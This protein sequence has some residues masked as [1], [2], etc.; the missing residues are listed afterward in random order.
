MA[1]WCITASVSPHFV[2]LFLFACVLRSAIP[3][4]THSSSTPP[5][6]LLL[7]FNSGSNQLR[8]HIVN[9]AQTQNTWRITVGLVPPSFS[10]TQ[11]SFTCVGSSQGGWAYV[12]GTGKKYSRKSGGEQA[13][14]VSYTTG[15]YVDIFFN[16]DSGQI[17]FAK[18][19]HHHGVAYDNLAGPV[20]L[21]VS[22]TGC[23]SKVRIAHIKGNVGSSVFGNEPAAAYSAASAAADYKRAVPQQS[24]PSGIPATDSDVIRLRTLETDFRGKLPNFILHLSDNEWLESLT[25]IAIMGFDRVQAA[26]ALIVTMEEHKLKVEAA[27]EYLLK[28]DVSKRAKYEKERIA[29]QAVPIDAASI[30]AASV[31][32]SAPHIKRLE[33]QVTDLLSQL[34]LERGKVAQHTVVLNRE[35]YKEALASCLVDGAITAA[36]IQRLEILRRK[37]GIE[38]GEHTRI[39]RELGV[40]VDDWDSMLDKGRDYDEEKLSESHTA[41]DL[42]RLTANTECVVCMERVVDHVVLDC[43]HVCYCGECAEMYKDSVKKCPKCR[44]AVRDIKKLFF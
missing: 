38:E 29:A 13:Y 24:L 41:S 12:G 27:I 11:R 7:S 23:G 31:S 22:M 42:I 19:G 6:L 39:L 5:P 33:A 4:L 3:P 2:S 14:G 36:E 28:D 16:F 34:Q 37:R 18:N 44:A 1:C 25:R 43:M 10:C 40:S 30:N 32:V 9:D 15:D 8:V 17:S 20:K 21:A 26:E 35:V